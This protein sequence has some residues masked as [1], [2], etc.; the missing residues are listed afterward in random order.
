M[1]D[2]IVELAG[3][4]I[5]RDKKAQ[6][7]DR[8]TEPFIKLD[9]YESEFGEVKPDYPSLKAIDFEYHAQEQVDALVSSGASYKEI[10]SGYEDAIMQ[11]MTI[12]EGNPEVWEKLNEFF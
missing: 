11:N 12:Q 1:V 5:E 2:T 7:A 6:K 9:E 3:E 8:L 10:V 4:Y